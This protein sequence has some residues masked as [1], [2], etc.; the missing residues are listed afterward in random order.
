MVGERHTGNRMRRSLGDRIASR[1]SCVD[2]W[3]V[4]KATI[5]LLLQPYA[6]VVKRGSF[7][8]ATCITFF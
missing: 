5:A 8:E 7:Y 1:K 3:N 4:Q 2:S 6:F